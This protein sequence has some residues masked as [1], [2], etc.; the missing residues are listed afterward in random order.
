MRFSS[1]VT[2]KGGLRDVSIDFVAS[3][4]PSWGD[5]I[6]LTLGGVAYDD[7]SG[8][9]TRFVKSGV[10]GVS[11][12]GFSKAWGGLTF[13][14][15]LRSDGGIYLVLGTVCFSYSCSWTRRRVLPLG[16]HALDDRVADDRVT[17]IPAGQRPGRSGSDAARRED[18]LDRPHQDRQVEPEAPVGDV[19]EVVAQLVGGARVVVA[20]DL[21]E[22]GWTARATEKRSAAYK[23]LG[24]VA[25][26]EARPLGSRA[27]GLISPRS[28]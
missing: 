25:L 26:H 28:T 10:S 14:G 16:P 20:G 9:G 21:G 4:D 18:D 17:T 11:G 24:Q 8:K 27:A 6:H 2:R 12:G 13:D 5:P 3:Q 19:G 15:E 23:G 7:V 22:P 1:T